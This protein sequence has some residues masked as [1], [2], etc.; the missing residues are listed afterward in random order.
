MGRLICVGV[1]PGP[2]GPKRLDTF[3]SPFEDECVSLAYGIKT[4][5][6]TTR[7]YFP[8]RG[9]QLFFLADIVAMEKGL[10]IKGHNAKCPCRSCRIR[11][12]N[13]PNSKNKTYYVPLFHPSGQT[14]WDPKNLPLRSHGDWCRATRAIENASTKKDK[15]AIAQK[16]G[17]KGMPA[18]S[19]VG[20]LNYARGMPWD[21]MHLLFENV[22]KNL[23]N[24]WMGSFKNLTSENEDFIIP[25]DIWKKIG[26]ETVNAVKYIPSQFVRSVKNLVDD[27]TTM[28]AE[29]WSFW[30]MYM[31]PI[32]LKNRL[33]EKYYRHACDLVTI[34]KMCTQFS[35]TR[36][37]VDEL[38][39]HIIQW[40]QRYEK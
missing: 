27:Q 33:V 14:A 34:M 4:F 6:C 3:V 1:I 5:D 30:F 32:L 17:I 35:I 16:T 26:K 21:F 38:E 19:R 31:A 37:E 8:L 29:A 12:V 23:F 2:K 7:D 24:M 20:S 18:F 15:E 13:D 22:V 36:E 39:E 9:Y 40:V 10:N 28:N 11:A 25:A